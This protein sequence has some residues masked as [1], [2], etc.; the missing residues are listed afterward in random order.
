MLTEE[1]EAMQSPT[2]RWCHYNCSHADVP[3]HLPAHVQHFTDQTDGIK[4][5]RHFS[6]CL[7]NLQSLLRKETAFA[8][9]KSP[10]V[11]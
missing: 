5:Q 11:M 9:W 1:V 7:T 10:I 8:M 2:K 6:I 3:V 4:V